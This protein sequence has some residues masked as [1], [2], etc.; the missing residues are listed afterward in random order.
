MNFNIAYKY[1]DTM[2]CLAGVIN[3]DIPNYT[4]LSLV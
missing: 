3:L 2:P 1:I 4:M